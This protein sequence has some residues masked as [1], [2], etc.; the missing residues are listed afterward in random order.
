MHHTAGSNSYST[1]SS[2]SIVRGI[3]AYHT[4]SRGWPDIGYQ[5]LVD[6]GG[7]IF[8]GRRDAI[9]DLPVGAQ[10]GG[11]NNQTIGISAIGN[12][13]TVS[14]PAVMVTSIER[15][16]AWKGYVHGLNATGKTT[17]ITGGSTGSGTRASSGTKVT[18]NV[19]QGHRDTNI[20]ACPGR[21]L[22][23]KLSSIRT[24]TKSR[25]SAA[26]SKYGAAKPTTAA[27]TPVK[28]SSSQS[29]V[30]RWGSSTFSW[31][32]VTGAVKYKVLTRQAG[33]SSS[34]PDSRTWT[35]YKTVSSPRATIKTS[36]GDTRLIAVRAVDSRGRLGPIKV[37]SQITRPLSSSDVVRSPSWN[38]RS[39]SDAFWD[40]YYESTSGTGSMRVDDVSQVR[41]VQIIGQTGPG[42]G[43]V[44]VTIGGTRV[45]TISFASATPRD[46]AYLTLGLSKSYSGTVRFSNLDSGK[47]VRISAVAFPRI[48]AAASPPA[49]TGEV[50]GSSTVAPGGSA[51]VA[52]TYTKDSALVSW[53]TVTLQQYSG[54][55]WVDAAPIPIRG[56]AGQVRVSPQVSTSYRVRNYNGSAVSPT[57]KVVVATTVT[58]EVVGSSTVAPGGSAVVTATYRK[59]G[60][61]VPSATVTLQRYS[62]GRW[63]DAVPISIRSGAG[64]AT[65]SPQTTTSYRV[66]NYNGSAV[67]STFKV[68]VD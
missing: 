14:P 29:P 13:D 41:Q 10:A 19:I 24:G 11:Y 66:R 12:Y 5:F 50:V 1:S 9:Y 36:T 40:K 21:Y 4:G 59:D 61:A 56:G 43:K 2:A 54:G 48:A 63:V 25:I 31:K 32:P 52:A 35:V 58:G 23:A 42:Y 45:G 38:L 16:L 60:A 55:R 22:Y 57:F 67:S 6:K 28:A 3:Y 33:Y 37:H 47:R 8:Q 46:A 65:V 26:V 30:A 15:V 18:V 51:V 62:G 17:L 34:M 7:K 39:D 44:A 68:V 49:V 53:A 27:P 64:R 20:T